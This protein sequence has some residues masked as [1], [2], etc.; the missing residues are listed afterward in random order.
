MASRR[1]IV[2]THVVVAAD[3]Q[4]KVLETHSP[5]A[6]RCLGP[7]APWRASRTAPPSAQPLPHTRSPALSLIRRRH[8][9]KGR[10]GWRTTAALLRPSAAHLVGVL[11]G[12]V[13]VQ[14]RAPPFRVRLEP[15]LER[16]DPL[17]LPRRQL[18]AL[19]RAA[20]LRSRAARRMVGGYYAQHHK[21]CAWVAI[22][23][24]C[25][26]CPQN[27]GGQGAIPTAKSLRATCICAC[28]QQLEGERM[29]RM[30][31]SLRGACQSCVRPGGRSGACPWRLA[32]LPWHR[33]H[34]LQPWI[35]GRPPLGRR[36]E[37]WRPSRACMEAPAGARKRA[38][39][40]VA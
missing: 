22:G 30:E 38:T 12:D 16:R 15:Q 20:R 9:L 23:A 40:R 32:H 3:Q 4:A 13:P 35:L 6:P 1:Y 26:T 17:A 2:T 8:P 29:S 28:M 14:T 27:L 33:A 18:A 11:A 19:G 34:A 7:C 24:L 31:L 5:P 37:A 21:R 39:R 36:L 25:G 10:P